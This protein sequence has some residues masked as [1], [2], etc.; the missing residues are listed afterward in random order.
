MINLFILKKY[1]SYWQNG[2][3][4]QYLMSISDCHCLT[5]MSFQVRDVTKTEVDQILN[6]NG[7]VMTTVAVI[8]IYFSTASYHTKVT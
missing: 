1:I 3:Y 5:L 7:K 8:A 4:T 2:L 6:M